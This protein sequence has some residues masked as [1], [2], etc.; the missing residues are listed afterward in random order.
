MLRVLPILLFVP[1]IALAGWIDR[2]GESLPDSDD[3]KAIGDFG[4]QM[5]FVSDE[6]ELFRQWAKPSVTVDVNTL[7]NV[8]VNGAVN[9]FVVF[10]G[11]KRDTKGNCSVAM[12]F[13]VLQPDGQIY[14]DTPPMEV[15]DEKPAPSAKS[16]ELSVQYLKVVIEPK[17]PSG[18]YIVHAQVRDNNSGAVLQLSR[19]F[20]AV[21]AGK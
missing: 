5:I 14:A 18:K 2:S 8:E 20:T 15:W 21:A 1:T 9:A 19:P 16:L 7:E 6:K 3:R 11:C 17:D 13:R 4:A 10:S 12:R